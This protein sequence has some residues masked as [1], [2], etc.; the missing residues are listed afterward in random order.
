MPDSGAPRTTQLTTY[1]FLLAIE[2][3]GDSLSG[4]DLKATLDG[5]L[6]DFP[7]GKVLET[8]LL[9]PLQVYPEPTK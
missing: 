4:E 5:M 3:E 7:D 9:G 6:I 1:G 2:V 8:E